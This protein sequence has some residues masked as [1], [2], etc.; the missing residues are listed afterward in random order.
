MGGLFISEESIVGSAIRLVYH[1]IGAVN[2]IIM[3][4]DKL[5]MTN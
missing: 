2:R 3:L 1:E 5:Y 4:V